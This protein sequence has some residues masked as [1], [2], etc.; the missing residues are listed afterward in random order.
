ML[1]SRETVLSCAVVLVTLTSLG[2]LLYGYDRLIPVAAA[3]QDKAKEPTPAALPQEEKKV[4]PPPIVQPKNP[5]GGF[6]G[7]GK[8]ARPQTVS[9]RLGLR[10]EPPSEDVALQLGLP[11]G[12]GMAIV[13]VREN[14]TAASAGLKVGDIIVELAGRPAPSDP[15]TFDFQM[16]DLKVATPLDAVVLRDG[17]METV[18][19]LV[20]PEPTPFGFR[21][22]RKL[23]P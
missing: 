14:S 2:T 19:G 12:E 16:S 4:E 5:F 11:E 7:F 15:R 17:K 6:R 18:K 3:V 1:L 13:D 23:F 9:E 20:L 8:K 10:V 22:K 21:P